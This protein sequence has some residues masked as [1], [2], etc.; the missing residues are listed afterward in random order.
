M[1]NICDKK[2]HTN[3]KNIYLFVKYIFYCGMVVLL[4]SD[5]VVFSLG[6]QRLVAVTLG[7]LCFYIKE[8][9]YNLLSY[10]FFNPFSIFRK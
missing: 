4:E 2:T 3:V 6:Q 9:K 5:R 1:Q 8:L 10:L 7:T